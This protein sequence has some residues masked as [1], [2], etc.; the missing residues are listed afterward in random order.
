M[1]PTWNIIIIVSILF[2]FLQVFKDNHRI[3]S[4]PKARAQNLHQ[5]VF[6]SPHQELSPVSSYLKGSNWYQPF[7]IFSEILPTALAEAVINIIMIISQ[8][9]S[10]CSR[11]QWRS[12]QQ[13][14]KFLPTNEWEAKSNLPPAQHFWTCQGKRKPVN[15]HLVTSLLGDCSLTQMKI[16]F[17]R[18]KNRKPVSAPSILFLARSKVHPCQWGGGSESPL[19]PYAHLLMLENEYCLKLFRKV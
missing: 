13:E 1:L 18:V 17:I 11:S 5:L 2:N 3:S 4:L 7:T 15:L 6:S 16:A 10:V 19:D 12:E 14:R 8:N 9:L